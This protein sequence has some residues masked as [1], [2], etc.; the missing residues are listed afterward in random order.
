MTD[1]TRSQKS[2]V[3]VKS[4]KPRSLNGE[5]VNDYGKVKEK[6]G[7]LANTDPQSNPHFSMH[8]AS[9]KGLG[10]EAEEMSHLESRIN[11]EVEER[12]SELR[13]KAIQEGFEQGRQEGKAEAEAAFAE[14]VKP[15]YEQFAKL[16]TEFEGLKEDLYRANEQFLVQLI[17]QIGKQVV[18]DDLKVNRDYVK[19]LAAQL[20]EKTG[21]KENIRIKVSREDFEN[22]EQIREYLKAQ[23]PDLKNVQIDPSEDLLLGGC[24]IETDL[25]RMNASVESQFRAIQAAIGET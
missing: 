2:G 12:I 23:F 8:P 13:N 9:K 11:V 21:A 4:F 16:V 6:F 22:V 18:L 7:S 1:F 3:E 5:V 10:V 17:F 20:V 19:R 24:K 25:S 14:S 15:L